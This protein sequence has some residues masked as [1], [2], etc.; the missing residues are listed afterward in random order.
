MIPFRIHSLSVSDETARPPWKP[1]PATPMPANR[2]Q[3]PG[4]L[5][6]E[7][8]TDD[9]LEASSATFIPDTLRTSS[10]AGHN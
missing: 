3:T 7:S 9:I 2:R 5:I 1:L 10:S 8:G 4:D 6:G